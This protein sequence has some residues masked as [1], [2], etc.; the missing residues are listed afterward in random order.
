[1]PE[2]NAWSQ[3]EQYPFSSQIYKTPIVNV[4]TLFHVFGGPGPDGQAE[5]T[6]IATFD[7]VSRSWSLSGFLKSGKVSDIK[8]VQSKYK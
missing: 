3:A 2:Y 7:S 6:V 4:D 5:D 8:L 1:M